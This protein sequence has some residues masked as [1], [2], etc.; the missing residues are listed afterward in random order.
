MAIPTVTVSGTA[1]S[2]DAAGTP[3]AANLTG[4]VAGDIAVVFIALD[5]NLPATIT[6]NGSGWTKRADVV[7]YALAWPDDTNTGVQSASLTTVTLSGTVW[8]ASTDGLGITSTTEVIGGNTYVVYTQYSFAGT[9]QYLYLDVPYVKFVRC[10]FHDTGAVNNTSALVQGP[11][12]LLSAIFEDCTFDGGGAGGTRNRGVSADHG[13]ITVRRSR[14]QFCGEAAI[15]KNDTSGLWSMDVSDS[16]ITEDRGWPPA[17][18]VDGLQMGGGRN[19]T[20]RHN[21]ILIAPYGG[22]TGDQTYVSNSCI[23]LF[24]ELGHFTGDVNIINNIVDGGGACFYIQEKASFRFQGAV[25]VTANV[26]W[27]SL[28]GEIPGGAVFFI[29]YPN[30]L[31]AALNW[32]GNAYD[33]GTSLSLAQAVAPI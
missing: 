33:D 8:R 26:I 15:E 13:D 18:H 25:N 19:F 17:Q 24:A 1:V 6:A 10:K 22:A 28:N 16:F 20:A 4:G 11:I 31:P 2:T 7:S 9:T 14:F 30:G 23:G 5:Q 29:L 27:R 3:I 32:A 12:E 21:S